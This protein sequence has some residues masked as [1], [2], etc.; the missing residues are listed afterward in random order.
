MSWICATFSGEQKGSSLA[1]NKVIV[2]PVEIKGESSPFAV[3]LF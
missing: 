1:W 3:F 2:R